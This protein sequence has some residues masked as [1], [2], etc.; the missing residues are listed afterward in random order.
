MFQYLHFSNSQIDASAAVNYSES[1]NSIE[2]LLHSWFADFLP[3]ESS[4]V[5]HLPSNLYWYEPSSSPRW[6]ERE[7]GWPTPSLSAVNCFYC[8]CLLRYQSPCWAWHCTKRSRLCFWG[9]SN[10]SWSVIGWR[11]SYNTRANVHSFLPIFFRV[12]LLYEHKHILRKKKR[13]KK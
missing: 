9:A 10:L 11:E 12:S 2:H 7:T 1:L 4:T 8:V 3:C 13:K 6:K 5:S